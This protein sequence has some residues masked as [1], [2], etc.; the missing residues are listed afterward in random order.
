[1]VLIANYLVR[2]HTKTDG[3]TSNNLT[4]NN[5]YRAAA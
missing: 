1:M 3:K 4:G 5:Y 2:E